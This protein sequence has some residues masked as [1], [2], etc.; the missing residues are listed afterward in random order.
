MVGRSIEDP[1]LYSAA[2][3]PPSPEHSAT[4]SARPTGTRR[5]PLIIA[6]AAGLA[7]MVVLATA[8]TPTVPS[9]TAAAADVVRI[10]ADEPS[11][12]DP[13]A[14]GDTTAA[15]LIPQLFETLTAFD[16]ELV[17]RPA[18]ARSWTVTD[19]GT[20]I[21]FELRPGLQFS[22]GSALTATDVVESW[23]RLI[24]PELPSPLAS[25]IEDVEDAE[26]YR[27]GDVGREA[28]GLRAVDGRVEVTLG[29]PGSDFPAIVAGASFAVVPPSV[30]RS[31]EVALQPSLFVG[32][33]GYV[34]GSMTAD[35]ISL[36]ANDRYWTGRP[37]IGTIELI[38]TNG[39]HVP[40]PDFEDGTVDYGGVFSSDAAWIRYDPGLGPQLRSVASPTV[41]YYGFDTSRPP[42]DDVLVRR[43]VGTAVDWRRIADLTAWPGTTRANSI[44]PPG[45]PGRSERDFLPAYDPDLA[46]E[47]LAQAGYPEGRGF[48]S[49]R[50]V[51]AGSGQEQAIIRELRDVLG[52]EIAY[53]AMEFGP[54]SDRLTT[55]PPAIWSL[56]WHADYPGRNDFL[57]I[58]LRTGSSS[59][60]GR[61]SSAEFDA[62]IDEALATTDSEIQRAA[63]DRAEEIVQR[64]VPVVPVLYDEDWAIARD[65]LLGAIDNGMGG[66]RLAG[67]AWR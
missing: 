3:A 63:F 38:T 37:A 41:T 67:L 34:L 64:D 27:R 19:D 66:L 44:V 28:V 45:I 6:L 46:R 12:L 32:S 24:D 1:D 39:S 61:W 40:V 26:A 10:A 53:E 23:L 33:G 43:A 52:I 59:N 54:Y 50:F 58:L 49:V 60:A 65:G 7:T 56:S 9:T 18:L 36:R 5:R 17:L 14:A 35:R 57:G 22:D 16:A 31:A 21:V 30:R 2:M 4:V 15:F 8:G 55:D 48:P 25:L 20:R 47:L 51:T 11:T 29:R 62:A 42:F 13:A